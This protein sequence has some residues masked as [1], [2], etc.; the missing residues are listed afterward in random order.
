MVGLSKRSKIHTWIIFRRDSPTIEN[1][2]WQFGG[3]ITGFCGIN[4]FQSGVRSVRGV[5]ITEF[6]QS[7]EDIPI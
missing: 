7:L 2:G 4:Q 3:P 1:Q 6:E 5:R